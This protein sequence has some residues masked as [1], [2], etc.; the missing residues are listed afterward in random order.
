MQPLVMYLICV[1]FLVASQLLEFSGG[2]EREKRD[3]R[4]ELEAVGACEFLC[5]AVT[6]VL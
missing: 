6:R 2:E 4:R 5:P 3:N 1:H